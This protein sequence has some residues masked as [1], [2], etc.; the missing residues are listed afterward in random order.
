M[1]QV[2]F[3]EVLEQLG[4]DSSD[5]FY[6]LMAEHWSDGLDAILTYNPKNGKVNIGSIYSNDRFNLDCGQI[7]LAR[8]NLPDK[9]YLKNIWHE[10][11]Y[12]ADKA[13][14]RAQEN[15]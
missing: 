10:I 6:E 1:K 2:T 14:E 4:C 13:L 12:E 5:S 11:V 7:L 3:N 15:Q 9:E 8:V